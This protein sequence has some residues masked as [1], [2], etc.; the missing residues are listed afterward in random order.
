[1]RRKVKRCFLFI[2]HTFDEEKGK[3]MFFYSYSIHL[4]RRKVKGCFFYSYS[5]HLM[6]RK[7]KGMF[8]LFI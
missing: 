8:F 5:I 6:R 7:V 2:K 3:G 4:M 1:M